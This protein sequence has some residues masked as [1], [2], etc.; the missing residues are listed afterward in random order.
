MHFSSSQLKE[1]H[2]HSDE[3]CMQVI[4]YWFDA[5]TSVLWHCWF[6][7]RKSIRPVKKFSDGVLAWLS[8]WGEVQMICNGPADDTATPSRFS[9]IQNGSAFLVPAYP[10]CP[11]KRPLNVC[12][13]LMLSPC[14]WWS[15]KNTQTYRIIPKE[16]F[17]IGAPCRCWQELLIKCCVIYL[18]HII[19][20]IAKCRLLR[21]RF[22]YP[23]VSI[24]AGLLKFKNETSKGQ[25]VERP[26]SQNTTVNYS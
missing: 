13:C 25:E 2:L 12:V 6:G 4:T 7:V 18:L 24:C 14:T 3:G 17:F 11:G 23:S 20:L 26:R 8:V 21:G 10:G 22:F 9:K 19:H 1:F 16:L 5:I 15:N